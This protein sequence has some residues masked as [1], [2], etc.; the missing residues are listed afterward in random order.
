MVK[1]PSKDIVALKNKNID[2][3]VCL[4]D[5]KV[6]DL[7]KKLD[8]IH[9][10]SKQCQH[11]IKVLADEYHTLLQKKSQQQLFEKTRMPDVQQ[12]CSLENQIHHVE[13][14]MMEAEHIRKKYRAIR[15]SLLEDGVAFESCL[16]GLE[17]SI[18]RQDVEIQ[19]LEKINNEALD[20]RDVT[21]S[22][23]SKQEMSALNAGRARERQLQDFRLRVEER[24]QELE[25]LERRIFPAGRP[26]MHH[27][28]GSSHSGSRPG[29]EQ[30][31]R[32][33]DELEN[34]FILLKEA[35]GETETE[36]VLRRFL[37]Q[38]ETHTRL[39]YLKN[40]TEQ[41][42][43]RLEKRRE[44][45]MADLEAFKFAEVKDKEQ[46]IMEME[47]LKKQ[48]EEERQNKAA[49]DNAAQKITGKLSEI[50]IILYSFCKKL[51]EIEGMPTIQESNDPQS[52][53]ELMEFLEK[54]IRRA[55]ELIGPDEDLD[56][57]I[58]S[59]EKNMLLPQGRVMEDALGAPRVPSV[60]KTEQK[61]TAVSE[62]DDEDEIPTRTFLKRQAQLIVDAKS[63]RKQFPHL[64]RNRKMR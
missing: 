23:L 42:K 20:L 54:I 57:K 36:Q 46:S 37:S 30:A 5:Y 43:L 60:Q 3:L 39:S 52:T 48:I 59:L 21:K 50:R 61:P 40:I 22:T 10:Q 13:M 14:N 18:Q 11:R 44:Y 32:L 12:V 53:Y 55:L 9:H 45:M 56:Q 15:T 1:K 47:I 8:L 33:T 28:S 19:H 29:T 24:R 58:A 64:M 31:D 25:R 62:T 38:R 49:I 17:H 26:M 35:T 6:I 4:L 2:E 41:E 63:R 27:D 34:A 7:K 51:Q 16:R